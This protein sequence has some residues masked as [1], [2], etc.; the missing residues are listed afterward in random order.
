MQ[1]F[2]SYASADTKLAERISNSIRASGFPVWDYSLIMPGENWGAKLAEALETSDAMILLLTPN[3]LHS[4]DITNDLSYAL[5]STA[6]KGRVIPVLAGSP[7]ELPREEIPWVL[8]RFQTIQMADADQ[9]EEGLRQITRAL[10]NAE[11]QN[12]VMV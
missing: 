12:G 11:A 3:S 8:N 10:Q 9:G 1:V 7:E 4:R 2:L 5:G 6:Y